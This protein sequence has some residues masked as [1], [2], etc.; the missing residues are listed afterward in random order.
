MFASPCD[1]IEIELLDSGVYKNVLVVSITRDHIE[2]WSDESQ[3]SIT[4]YFYDEG[5]DEEL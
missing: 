5:D 1:G 3:G 2:R 4:L